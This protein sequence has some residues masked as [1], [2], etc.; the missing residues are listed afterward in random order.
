M[1]IDVGIMTKFFFKIKNKTRPMDSAEGHF[2]RMPTDTVYGCGLKIHTNGSN[3]DVCQSKYNDR[4]NRS[5][6]G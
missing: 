1:G 3:N 6:C 2:L 5:D 4:P